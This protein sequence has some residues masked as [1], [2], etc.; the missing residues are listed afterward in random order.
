MH[1]LSRE[2]SKLLPRTCIQLFSVQSKITTKKKIN[3]ENN[4]SKGFRLLTWKIPYKK[5]PQT[6][7]LITVKEKK[8]TKRMV[9]MSW[10]QLKI[11]FK[12]RFLLTTWDET[13]FRWNS[14][15]CQY[16]EVCIPFDGIEKDSQCTGYYAKPTQK[17]STG[18]YAE[19]AA[20]AIR[21]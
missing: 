13:S 15:C 4:T 7:M 19:T 21:C 17:N 8:N 20:T 10:I 6:I 16:I 11:Y 9:E 1:Q 3:S 14:L 2:N 5:S 18:S 12:I